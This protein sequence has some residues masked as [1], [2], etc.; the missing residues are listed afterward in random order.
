MAEQTIPTL[1]VI[2]NLPIERVDG[3]ARIL[4]TDLATRLGFANPIDISKL[5]RRH[6]AALAALGVL[7]T[8]ATTPNNNGL[9]G[10]PREAAYLNRK[11]AIFITAKSD[12]PDA[13]NLTIEIIEKFDAYERG[14]MLPTHAILPD[15]C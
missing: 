13:T 7:A 8:V 11:Q 9:G 5:I 12:T 2:G 14:G 6:T 15:R 10:R 1:P 3:E 4:D